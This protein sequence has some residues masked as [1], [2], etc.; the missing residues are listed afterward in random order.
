MKKTYYNTKISEIEKKLTDRKHDKYITT[1][2]F[3]KLN[4]ETFTTRLKQANLVIKT[5][6][7]DKLKNFNQ[8]INSN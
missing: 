3:N 8:K 7:D 6:F 5:D 2:E 1:T 4:A